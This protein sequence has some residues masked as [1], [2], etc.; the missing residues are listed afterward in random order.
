[1]TGILSTKS[2]FDSGEIKQGQIPYLTSCFNLRTTLSHISPQWKCSKTD[3][4]FRVWTL[5][6]YGILVSFSLATKASIHHISGK[7]RLVLIFYHI[8]CEFHSSVIIPIF[9]MSFR[10][11]NG[12]QLWMLPWWM[13]R[14]N[15]CLRKTASRNLMSALD[16]RAVRCQRYGRVYSESCAAIANFRY[17]SF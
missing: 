13:K 9:T 17:A 7:P 5:L 15:H 2:Q 10:L 6:S 1:M 11:P 12:Q 8:P 14:R 4:P 3:N 16:G